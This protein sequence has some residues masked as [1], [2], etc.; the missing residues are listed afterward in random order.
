MTWAALLKSLPPG[1]LGHLGL[2]VERFSNPDQRADAVEVLLPPE[3]GISALA[4]S[5]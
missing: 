4:D 5:G 1:L 3:P 2:R